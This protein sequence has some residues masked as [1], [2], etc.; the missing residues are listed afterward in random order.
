MK[1]FEK[2]IKESEFRGLTPKFEFIYPELVENPYFDLSNYF[3]DPES[4]KKRLIRS[5]TMHERQEDWWRIASRLRQEKF[6]ATRAREDSEIFLINKYLE[7]N[8]GRLIAIPKKYILESIEM[9]IYIENVHWS[10]KIEEPVDLIE[11]QY[12]AQSRIEPEKNQ[13]IHT[14]LTLSNLRQLDAFLCPIINVNH[15][16]ICVWNRNVDVRFLRWCPSPM[17]WIMWYNEIHDLGE[18][19]FYQIPYKIDERIKL[20]LRPSYYFATPREQEILE[21]C[22]KHLDC[23][24][25]VEEAAVYLGLRQMDIDMWGKHLNYTTPEIYIH[26]RKLLLEYEPNLDLRNLDFIPTLYRLREIVESRKEKPASKFDYRDLE[27]LDQRIDQSRVKDY[28]SNMKDDDFGASSSEEGGNPT[29]EIYFRERKS[30]DSPRSDDPVRAIRKVRFTHENDSSD[31]EEVLQ[32]RTI[33][34]SDSVNEDDTESEF[35]DD[36]LP[37][38]EDELPPYHNVITDS[39]DYQESDSSG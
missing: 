8:P 13:T 6:K 5:L 28:I 32:A 15:H 39:D 23:F 18:P 22:D 7:K 26:A 16:T 1:K 3:V 27:L 29:E 37:E 12:R 31:E 30:D 10:N 19:R 11:L 17:H 33:N 35:E 25:S 24:L 36:Y 9:D 38:E 20:P 14:D 4:V 21:F 2:Q 34:R